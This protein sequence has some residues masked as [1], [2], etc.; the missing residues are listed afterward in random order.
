MHPSNLPRIEL[1]WREGASGAI[2]LTGKKV[3]SYTQEEVSFQNGDVSLRGTLST[4]A[5]KGLHP[6]LVLIHGSGPARRPGGFWI[7]FFA[8]H[9]IAVLVFDK[10]GAGE[11]TGD[12][13]KS[14]YQDLAA[15]ALAAVQLLKRQKGIDPK[16]I[17]LWGNS[18]GGWVAPLAAS[19]STDIAFLIVRSGSALPTSPIF[20]R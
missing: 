14:T 4:P 18:E 5:T 9:G 16:Q 19:Q 3:D 17:G 10:R 20:S 6:A 1:K 13:R 12:W 2:T 8:R 15:D 11:S 7:P